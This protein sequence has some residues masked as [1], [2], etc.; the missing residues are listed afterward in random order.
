MHRRDAGVRGDHRPPRL[1]QHVGSRTDRGVRDV[2]HDSTAL[3]GLD[4]RPPV[5]RQAA[6]GPHAEADARRA[7]RVPREVRQR[8][9][10]QA[11]PRPALQRV[12][13]ALER[14]GPFESEGVGHRAPPHRPREAARPRRPLQPAAA[15]RGGPLHQRQL[16]LH[17]REPVA[18]AQRRRHQAEEHA[19]E[20][21]RPQPRQVD[22]PAQR[23]A[24]QQRPV[25]PQQVV[26]QPHQRRGVRVQVDRRM[27]GEQRRHV[28]RQGTLHAGKPT[29]SPGPEKELD[30]GRS[31]KP[32]YGRLLGGGRSRSAEVL[33]VVDHR[34]TQRHLDRVGPE[35]DAPESG[36]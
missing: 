31:R 18:E 22:V 2:E 23:R 1:R 19:A 5:A 3:A 36:G 20:T 11:A 9:V 8:Q 35:P 17:A 26:A 32:G 13:P 7:G 30:D 4:Q 29:G 21:A 34:A 16:P 27:P 33:D 14:L 25:P 12:E 24:R 28:R 15:R 6:V 10:A